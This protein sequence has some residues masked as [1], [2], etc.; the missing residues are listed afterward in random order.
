MKRLFASA[1]LLGATL[2][3]AAAAESVALPVIDNVTAV[4]GNRKIT[5][6]F[7]TPKG[8]SLPS[9]LGFI[10]RTLPAAGECYVRHNSQ[11]AMTT[12]D[13]T[14]LTNGFYYDVIVTTELG[15]TRVD[16]K[17]VT[18][19]QPTYDASAKFSVTA[20]M[21]GALSK[22]A[23]TLTLNAAGSI[24]GEYCMRVTYIQAST[25]TIAALGSD[26]PYFVNYLQ[27]SGGE[28]PNGLK[29][30]G[31]GSVGGGC[32]PLGKTVLR[33]S[34][35]WPSEMG[36]KKP[37][38]PGKYYVFATLSYSNADF[39]KFRAPDELVAESKLVPV[40]LR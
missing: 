14:A 35:A 15:E 1:L 38:R 27:G 17:P 12:C 16:S 25:A 19:V 29:L 6:S 33:G 24:A 18:R 30:S 32:L 26:W 4:G 39:R 31:I 7:P 5:V 9:G 10:A 28:L 13:I 37:T 36:W 3:P 23:G 40:T 21:S 11:A 34:K 8:D 20:K 2:V 22:S